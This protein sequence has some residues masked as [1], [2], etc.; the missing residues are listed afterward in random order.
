MLKALTCYIEFPRN[1]SDFCSRIIFN[2]L[3]SILYAL[4]VSDFL[5]LTLVRGILAV[6]CVF[7]QNLP[8]L[9]ISTTLVVGMTDQRK[10]GRGTSNSFGPSPPE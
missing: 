5:G 7:D 3:K 8:A 10:G 6:E 4:S 1:H 2:V 9:V